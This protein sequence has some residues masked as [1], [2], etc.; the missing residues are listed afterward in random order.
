M[1]QDP[2]FKGVGLNGSWQVAQPV[3]LL[4]Q[5]AQG[6]E[7][8]EQ[9]DPLVLFIYP[10]AQLGQKLSLV[11]E[12][13]F[14][15]LQVIQLDTLLKTDKM[16]LAWQTVQLLLV[17]QLTQLAMLQV[18]QLNLSVLALKPDAHWLHWF[19]L[20]HCKQLVMLH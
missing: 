5:V 19:W 13:Q 12:T 16:K 1:K 10:A 15:T 8:R 11:Q 9:V 20:L 6:E 17:W 4:L 3:P 14:E 18:T 2:S 7:Q